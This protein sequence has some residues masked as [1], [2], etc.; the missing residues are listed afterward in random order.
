[1]KSTRIWLGV[2]VPV[3]WVAIAIIAFAA[4]WARLPDPLATHWGLS[5]APN[6]AMPR[7]SAL[8]VFGG[9]S[10]LAAIGARVAMYRDH[11]IAQLAGGATFTG[12]LFATLAV[13]TVRANFD[14]ARWQD[15]HAVGLPLVLACCGVAGVVAALATRAARALEPSRTTTPLARPTIGLGATERAV[16]TASAKNGALFVAAFV[17]AVAAVVTWASG[18]SRL[19]VVSLA[20][21]AIVASAL[22]E[23]RVRVDDRKVTIAFGPL[24]F[25]RIRVAV[26]RITHAATTTVRP[27]EHGG[28]G[29]RG[30]LTALG[31]AAVVVRGGEGLRL[32]LRGDKTMVITIDDAETG[33]G[34][35]NDLVAR[36]TA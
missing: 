3:A 8:A 21:A 22:T 1:M 10:L 19:V 24:G 36:R 32:D 2:V 14:A 26:D 13:V 9:A 34:L 27:M 31:R 15:A 30:S 18:G 33:A 12:V 16:W 7:I 29:Y 35:I 5:G 4:T 17:V 20:A 11:G 25:P 28:W 6:G 23:V